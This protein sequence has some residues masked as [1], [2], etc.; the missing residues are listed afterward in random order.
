[1]V[2]YPGRDRRACWPAAMSGRCSPACANDLSAVSRSCRLTGSEV[3]GRSQWAR[4]ADGHPF[5]SVQGGGAVWVGPG[6]SVV[7]PGRTT[8]LQ[9]LLRQPGA[10]RDRCCVTGGLHSFPG[11]PHRHTTADGAALPRSGEPCATGLA[12]GVLGSAVGRRSSTRLRCGAAGG[13]VPGTARPGCPRRL[14]RARLR[15]PRQVGAE[16]RMPS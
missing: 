3:P 8:A 4:T 14:P 16:Q 9:R 13:H 7:R 5:G 2:R 12:R 11:L 6:A 10:G 15:A 1:L